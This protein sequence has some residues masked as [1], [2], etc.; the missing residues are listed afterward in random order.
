MDGEA[1]VPSGDIS[2][3]VLESGSLGA[4]PEPLK[5]NHLSAPVTLS[6][7]SECHERIAI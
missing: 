1:D 3:L 4:L 2:D 6:F 5:L 7:L